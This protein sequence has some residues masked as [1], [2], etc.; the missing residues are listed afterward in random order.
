MQ[1]INNLVA[2]NK[3]SRRAEFNYLILF[4]I[5]ITLVNFIV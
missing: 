5:L 1:T 4:Y 3:K 2:L